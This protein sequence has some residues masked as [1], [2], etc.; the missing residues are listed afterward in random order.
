MDPTPP[1][2]LRTERLLLREFTPDDLDDVHAY[3]C[4]DA[5]VRY[6][7]WGPNTLEQTR[8]FLAEEIDRGE[9]ALNADHQFHCAVMSAT[10]NQAYTKVFDTIVAVFHEGMRAMS[11]DYGSGGN[12]L[13]QHR[14][15][16]DAVKKHQPEQARNLMR[17]H[18][19]NL[20]TQLSRM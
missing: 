13:E 8:V 2:S 10:H 16:Y 9:K 15:I 11:V 14:L 7:D 1:Y 12:L 5:T 6:M 3:A 19:E 17:A 18:L 4:D 20:E